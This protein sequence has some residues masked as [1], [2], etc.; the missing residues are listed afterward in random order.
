MPEDFLNLLY[1][2]KVKLL[3]I[4]ENI[5]FYYDS[6]R[7]A[8]SFDYKAEWAYQDVIRDLKVAIDL[9]DVLIFE[10]VKEKTQG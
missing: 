9:C 4:K 7:A 2:Q 8:E 10:R 3:A 6:K 5:E 1:Q